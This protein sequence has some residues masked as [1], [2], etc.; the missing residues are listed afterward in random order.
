MKSNIFKGWHVHF[1][2]EIAKYVKT[3]PSEVTVVGVHHDHRFNN[4]NLCNDPAIKRLA[5]EKKIT[6]LVL[7]IPKQF[8]HKKAHHS[9]E[10]N[11]LYPTHLQGES[12][13]RDF[14]FTEGNLADA[15]IRNSMPSSK[16]KS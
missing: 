11:K 9:L 4:S 2:K 16:N 15:I 8:A 6:R 14:E 3:S 13:L 12:S 5:K 10:L 7:D 1:A